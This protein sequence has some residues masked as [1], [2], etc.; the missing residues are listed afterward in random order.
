LDGNVV[1]MNAKYIEWERACDGVPRPV[2]RYTVTTSLRERGTARHPTSAEL[3]ALVQF[4]NRDARGYYVDC[5]CQADMLHDMSAEERALY[6]QQR[7]QLH[8]LWDESSQRWHVRP[9]DV[10]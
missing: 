2:T 4:I 1:R 3:D 6:W 10:A 8:R 9:T 5:Q 7:P